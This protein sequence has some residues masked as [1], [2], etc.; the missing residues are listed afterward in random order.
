MV[1]FWHTIE[2]NLFIHGTAAI[3]F[4][5]LLFGG[6][7]KSFTRKLLSCQCDFFTIFNWQRVIKTSLPKI[8]NFSRNREVVWT[9]IH[10]YDFSELLIKR[11]FWVQIPFFGFV[12]WF[13]NGLYV[14][15]D[16]FLS[17]NWENLLSSYDTFFYL[18]LSGKQN[19][20][21]KSSLHRILLSWYKIIVNLFIANKFISIIRIRIIRNLI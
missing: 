21:W 9:T 6:E 11:I 16:Y 4:F 2:S 10:I 3:F 5:L 20:N 8:V 14:E 18:K 7:M 17:H 1:W 12:L 15:F 13:F 19:K